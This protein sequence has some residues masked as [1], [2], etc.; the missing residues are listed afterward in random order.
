[1]YPIRTDGVDDQIRSFPLTI[2]SHRISELF[3]IMPGDGTNMKQFRDTVKLMDP[4]GMFANQFGVDIGLRWP[5]LS[6]EVPSD[7]EGA[8]CS[9]DP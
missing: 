1:M 4:T 8:S 7:T 3:S 6:S 5:Q 2:S 9:V